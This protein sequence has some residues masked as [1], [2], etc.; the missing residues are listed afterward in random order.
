MTMSYCVLCI[1]EQVEGQCP[2]HRRRDGDQTKIVEVD[3]KMRDYQ[4]YLEKLFR[5]FPHSYHKM[6]EFMERGSCRCGTLDD[7]KRPCECASTGKAC[8]CSHHI[9]YCEYCPSACQTGKVD[10][11]VR[12][13]DIDPKGDKFSDFV[14]DDKFHVSNEPDLHNLKIK[15]ATD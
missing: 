1:S 10:D 12:V 5:R 4:T 8:V 2:G 3:K 15:L 6:T 14:V 13:Y 11:T 7:Q 9:K